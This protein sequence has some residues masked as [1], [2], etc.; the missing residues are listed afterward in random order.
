MCVA[1]PGHETDLLTFASHVLDRQHDTLAAAC[2][3]LQGGQHDLQRLASLA[4]AGGWS[5]AIAYETREF[6]NATSKPSMRVLNPIQR[7][8]EQALVANI[9]R[10]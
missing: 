8:R 3:G 1:K 2:L 10:D 4:T 9:D 5:T 6:R 7:L